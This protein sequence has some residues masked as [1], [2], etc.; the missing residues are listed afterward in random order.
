MLA[1]YGFQF[2]YL[3]V[4]ALVLHQASAI[5]SDAEKKALQWRV[6]VSS[7]NRKRLL[8]SNVSGSANKGALHAIIGP[9][10]SGKTTLLNILAGTV[11]RQLIIEGV[12]SCSFTDSPIYVQQVRLR[13][14]ICALFSQSNEPKPNRRICSSRS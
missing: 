7:K 3:L 14:Q 10:G 6:T 8:L 11:S 13:L 9:S 1:K 5:A 12:C 2:L 4:L